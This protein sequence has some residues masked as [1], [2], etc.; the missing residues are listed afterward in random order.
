MLF[1]WLQ[2]NS[3]C[4]G[5]SAYINKWWR[6]IFYEFQSK[7]SGTRIYELV[8]FKKTSRQPMYEVKRA[9][10]TELIFLITSATCLQDAILF[11]LN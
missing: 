3:S 8:T 6:C 5:C 7:Q 4:L 10:P 9:A 11:T 2:P 1:L